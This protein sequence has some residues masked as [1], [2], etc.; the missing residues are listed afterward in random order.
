MH[1]IDIFKV[2]ISKFTIFGSKELSLWSLNIFSA[3]LRYVIMNFECSVTFEP[4]TEHP[5]CLIDHRKS[6]YVI[7]T[8]SIASHMLTEYTDWAPMASYIY[9]HIEWPRLSL[10][11]WIGIHCVHIFS[12]SKIFVRNRW[13]ITFVVD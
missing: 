6:L 10:C 2:R 9:V 4:L 12:V 5:S 3:F 7:L 8:D 1:S 13:S 11:F